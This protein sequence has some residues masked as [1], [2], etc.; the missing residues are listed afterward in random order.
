MTAKAQKRV[1]TA[2]TCKDHLF[3]I[4]CLALNL[5][6]AIK[7]WPWGFINA[8]EQLRQNIWGGKHT[9]LQILYKKSEDSSV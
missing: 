7:P 2:K 8:D 9:Y 5:M 6:A 3:F 4:F 1:I